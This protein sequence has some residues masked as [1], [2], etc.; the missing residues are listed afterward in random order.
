MVY[1]FFKF[2]SFEKPY[3]CALWWWAAKIRFNISLLFLCTFHISVRSGV[4]LFNS[5]VTLL[6]HSCDSVYPPAKYTNRMITKGHSTNRQ[7]RKGR[8]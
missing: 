4:A 6:T 8:K 5:G 3:K 2:Y 7:M 1:L